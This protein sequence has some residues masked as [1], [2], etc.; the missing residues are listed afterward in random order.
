MVLTAQYNAQKATHTLPA[1][2]GYYR[3]T[4]IFFE[5]H[6]ALPNQAD[7]SPLKALIAYN[8]LVHPDHPLRKKGV[9]GIELYLGKSSADW[10]T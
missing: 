1:I 7:V 9:N 3:F 5:W 8:A 10:L 4:D 6:Q 2:L